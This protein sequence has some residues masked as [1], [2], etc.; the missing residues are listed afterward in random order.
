MESPMST[1]QYP[2]PPE[3]LIDG[4]ARA[5]AAPEHFQIPTPLLINE[6]GIGDYMK[7]GLTRPDGRGERFWVRLTAIVREGAV[8]TFTGTVANDLTLFPEYPDGKLISFRQCHVLDVLPDQWDRGRL[9]SAT[10][11]IEKN[12]EAV[13]LR[14][15]GRYPCRDTPAQEAR[16]ENDPCRRP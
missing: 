13:P 16:D 3:N 2:E 1:S 9:P 11:L 7:I 15:S 14:A 5:K 10:T 12:T 4:I 6:M 8:K